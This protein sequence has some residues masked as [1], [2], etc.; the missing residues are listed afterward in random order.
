MHVDR[1]SN[2][3]HVFCKKMVL[4]TLCNG[5]WPALAAMV[6]SEMVRG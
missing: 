6:H 5:L 1:K 3:S 2:C 4:A